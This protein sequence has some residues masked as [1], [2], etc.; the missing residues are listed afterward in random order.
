M[1]S[2]LFLSCTTTN[3]H[4]H[5]LSDH[6]Q[7]FVIYKELYVHDHFETFVIYKKRIAC[8]WSFANSCSQTMNDHDHLW[9]F[10]TDH[11]QLPPKRVC[12]GSHPTKCGWYHYKYAEDTLTRWSGMVRLGALDCCGCPLYDLIVHLLSA[13]MLVCWF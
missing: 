2:L 3:N 11:I 1:F 7:T 4:D 10:M 8:S 13:P 6:F 5:L 9:K 12:K